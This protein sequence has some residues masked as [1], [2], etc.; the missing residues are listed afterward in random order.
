MSDKSSFRESHDFSSSCARIMACCL[1]QGVSG[2]DT[3]GASASSGETLDFLD[4][5]AGVA[6]I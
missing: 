4:F 2:P 3:E 1:R 6:G 5:G